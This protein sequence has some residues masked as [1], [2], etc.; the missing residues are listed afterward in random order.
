MSEILFLVSS[1]RVSTA[2]PSLEGS[3]LEETHST[4]DNFSM[5]TDKDVVVDKEM[6]EKTMDLSQRCSSEA[7]GER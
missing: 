4:L 3:C 6:L 1:G 5:T 2:S 7:I